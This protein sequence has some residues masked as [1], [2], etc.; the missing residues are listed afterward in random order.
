M[1]CQDFMLLSDEL[2]RTLS[3][4]IKMIIFLYDA[5]V[6]AKLW[7]KNKTKHS[8]LAR[9]FL[10]FSSSIM[11]AILFSA[12]D[13]ILDWQNILGDD[14]F[15]GMGLAFI[16]TSIANIFFLWIIMEVFLVRASWAKNQKLV[17]ILYTLFSIGSTS[18]AFLARFYFDN[19]R[20]IFMVVFMLV[21][22]RIYYID[23]TEGIIMRNRVNE[24]AYKQ[25]FQNMVN[26][27]VSM[28]LML[29]FFG[30]DSF[31]TEFTIYSYLGWGMA[32]L[33]LYFM[34]KSFL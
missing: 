9:M 29:V 27:G 2:G 15:L 34:D 33:N 28:I 13:V 31:F 30:I 19:L 16:F 8:R 5:Y 22:A 11:F 4:I 23:V 6:V 10:L 20:I 24:K 17:F 25:R 18:M 14:T 32:A 26:A 21:S 12:F 3:P 7:K 1:L